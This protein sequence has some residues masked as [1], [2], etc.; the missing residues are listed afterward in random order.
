MANGKLKAHDTYYMD[1]RMV[2][3]SC[4]GRLFKIPYWHLKKYCP[5]L[6]HPAK[7]DIGSDGSSDDTA[8]P[9]DDYVSAEEFVIFLDFFYRGILHKE[10]PTDEW[11]K[12]LV[13]SSKLDCKEA[14]AR[15][16]D[17]ITA[18]KAKVS[19]I[20]RIELG[21]K[22]N[23]SQWLPEAYAD[24]FVRGSHL[25]VEEGEKLGLEIAVKVLKGRD[26][27]K[28]NGWDSSGDSNVTWLVKDI[29]PVQNS[30][31][32]GQRRRNAGRLVV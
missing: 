22:Y 2:V 26:T 25:T 32:A 13:V 17:E 27:C 31:T 14:R 20:D 7:H 21:N 28:K 19:S 9:I 12:L 18:K 16:I 3:L 6:L 15:A 29:F 5:I 4:S 10:I 24:A 30:P 1:G 11:C 23:V 8:I